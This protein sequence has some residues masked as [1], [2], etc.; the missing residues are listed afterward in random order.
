MNSVFILDSFKCFTEING[1]NKRCVF[2]GINIIIFN[3]IIS[4]ILESKELKI[5]LPLWMG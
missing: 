3:T 5:R 1:S 4:L 2:Q